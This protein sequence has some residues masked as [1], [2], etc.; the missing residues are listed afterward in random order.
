MLR[1]SAPAREQ[2]FQLPLVDVLLAAGAKA[3]PGAVEITLAHREAG[4]VEALVE[5]GH[6]LTAPIAA[7]L[8]RTADLPEG[9]PHEVVHRDDLVVLP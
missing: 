8:G 3:T 7:A 4:I 5:R 6:P 1:T 9:I 2:G